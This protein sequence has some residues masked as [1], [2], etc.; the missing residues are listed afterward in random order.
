MMASEPANSDLQM[1]VKRGCN[2]SIDLQTRSMTPLWQTA[3][4]A[5]GPA[6]PLH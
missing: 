1:S 4:G 6:N 2:G 5:T 3:S